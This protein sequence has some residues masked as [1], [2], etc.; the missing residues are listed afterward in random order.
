MWH[1]DP[2]KEGGIRD[3]IAVLEQLNGLNNGTVERKIVCREIRRVWRS[4]EFPEN[5]ITRNL[6]IPAKIPI[7]GTAG[8]YTLSKPY[9]LWKK[10][11]LPKAVDFFTKRPSEKQIK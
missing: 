8:S 7:K 1:R 4:E 9:A 5:S 11:I 10:L 3:P 2:K 6:K